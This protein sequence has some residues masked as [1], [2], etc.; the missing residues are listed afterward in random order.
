ME[1]PSF[2]I[3]FRKSTYIFRSFLVSV[4]KSKNTITHMIRYSLNRSITCSHYRITDF[5]QFTAVA[6]VE[7]GGGTLY[8]DH[9]RTSFTINNH[10]YGWD[11]QQLL[12]QFFAE[13]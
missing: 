11:L 3:L 7:R 4:G 2:T 12:L 5:T 13:F 9:Q 8:P 10:I 6:L 1:N